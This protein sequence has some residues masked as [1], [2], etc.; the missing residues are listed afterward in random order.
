MINPSP[1]LPEPTRVEFSVT[2]PPPNSRPR[3]HPLCHP[4]SGC[5]SVSRLGARPWDVVE[6]RHAASA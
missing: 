2:P 3:T 6:Q 1:N 5:A 4:H